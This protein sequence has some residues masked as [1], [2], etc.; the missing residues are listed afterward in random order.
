VVLSFGWPL[1][2]NDKK[3]EYLMEIYQS[4]YNRLKEVK[5]EEASLEDISRLA[6]SFEYMKRFPPL[7]QKNIIGSDESFPTIVYNKDI[8]LS[9]QQQNLSQQINIFLE[10]SPK[11]ESLKVDRFQGI[12]HQLFP[13]D[14]LLTDK[15]TNEIKAAI[16]I[17][18]N[19]HYSRRLDEKIVL[20][21]D[22]KL[23]TRLFSYRYPKVPW[24]RV[25]L[26]KE[27][28]VKKL[29]EWISLLK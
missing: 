25:E 22:A 5:L 12:D 2:E 13:V 7:F 15:N 20:R 17:A 27:E 1:V 3:T 18:E 23:K 21:R 26:E 11:G 29:F 16:I 14:V 10:S 28:S 24:M 4:L 9:P 19:S 6:I 8:P